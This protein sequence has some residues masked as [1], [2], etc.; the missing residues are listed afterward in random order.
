MDFI[1]CGSE[2]YKT[3]GEVSKKT[4]SKMLGLLNEYQT[5]T[6]EMP[7]DIKGYESDWRK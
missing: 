2:S 3:I 1:N 4:A 6:K 5:K 7:E